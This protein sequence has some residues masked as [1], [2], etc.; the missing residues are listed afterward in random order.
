MYR[1]KVEDLMGLFRIGSL[2]RRNMLLGTAL[3]GE[4][5][6]FTLMREDNCWFD[7]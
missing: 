6:I 4:I 2:R 3:Q 7:S 5:I 1:N